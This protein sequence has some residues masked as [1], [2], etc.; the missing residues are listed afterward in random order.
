MNSRKILILYDY[1]DPAYKAGGPIRSLVNLVR[2]MEDLVGIHIITSNQDH[3]GFIMNVEPDKWTRYGKSAK[4]L[5][6]SKRNRG[7]H[8]IKKIITE[9]NPEVVYLNGMYSVHFLVYPLW[10]LRNWK[11]IKIII[12]PRG[13]LQ[14]ESLSIK[15]IKKKIYLFLVKH[16]LLR[17]EINWHVT[18]IQEKI[19][20]QNVIGDAKEIH[21]VGNVPHYQKNNKIVSGETQERKIFGTVALISPMKNIHLILETLAIIPFDLTYILYGPIKDQQYWSTCLDRI[22]KLPLN[23]KVR[24]E[25]EISPDRVSEAIQN[26]DFYIQPSK[27]ENFGHSIFEAFNLGVPV[28]ISDQTPWKFLQK[29]NAGWDVDLTDPQSLEKA[30]RAAIQMDDDT[31]LEYR[32][33]S[34]K[35]AEDYMENHDFV[36]LYKK[37]FRVRP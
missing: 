29:K 24:Y 21:E 18:T 34:R 30:I 6:L 23:I 32:K 13:M 11:G 22:K 19:D 17:K 3:D 16:F 25:G 28:I 26:F 15:P 14:S 1:F 4:V 7:L 5:Y 9:V 8:S 35:V 31:Y 12:A 37:L 20:L 27:S 33:G 2:L 10:I 36:S